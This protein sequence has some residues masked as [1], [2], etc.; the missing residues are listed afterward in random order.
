[1]STIER[2]ERLYSPDQAARLLGCG[3]ANV[4][5]L[6]KSGELR[7]IKIGGL[8]RIRASALNELIAASEED[9]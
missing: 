5:R 3:R 4:Y 7:S 8:R 2:A 9:S 6:I 1:M